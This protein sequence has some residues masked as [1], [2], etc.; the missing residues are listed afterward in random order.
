MFQ[1]AWKQGSG[2]YGA[3]TQHESL[4]KAKAFVE[5]CIATNKITQFDVVILDI[6]KRQVVAFA[7]TTPPPIQW[8]TV[9]VA[10]SAKS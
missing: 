7:A 8:G 9:T 2:L 4:E 6:D 1:V 5:Q 3:S 10:E